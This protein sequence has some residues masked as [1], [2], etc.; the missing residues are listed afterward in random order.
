M[1]KQCK[2]NV[3]HIS[4]SKK[5]CGKLWETLAA[6]KPTNW[7]WSMVYISLHLPFLVILILGMVYGCLWHWV[8]HGL[9]WFTT[10]PYVTLHDPTWDDLGFPYVGLVGL[11]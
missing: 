11:D 10:L 8:Y 2:T 9:H 7:G 1:V 6:I 4:K 3:K 5:T